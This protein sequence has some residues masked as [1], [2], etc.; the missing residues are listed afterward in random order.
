M[1]RIAAIIPAAGLGTRMGA[2]TPKQFL[3][4]DGMPL[5]IFTLK[6]LATCPAITDFLIATRADGIS[7]LEGKIAK[8]A[9]GRPARVVQGGDTRQQSVANAL[10]QVDPSTEIV[11]VHDAVRPFVT[12]EQVERVIAEARARGAAILG[13]PAIDT[14]KEVKRASLPEDVALISA[15][16]P[17][18]RIVL[19]QTPQVFS[20][21]LLR[22]AFRKAQDDDV[23]A[24]DE[25][26]VVERFGHEVFVVLGSERN[27]KITR[28]ADM[29]LARF[30]LEQER[31]T[32]KV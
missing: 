24:S 32:V 14:V 13:I 5:I 9:L 1:G 30:Y 11:L 27:L 20:Y 22:D 8:A 25:A 19:A 7:S 2:E 6:R 12:R 17:R 31:Q 15:T 23:S 10:A 26:A 29:D 18:E 3:E 28:P 16:I 21:A 4:L